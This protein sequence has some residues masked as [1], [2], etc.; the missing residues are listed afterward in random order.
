MCKDFLRMGYSNFLVDPGVRLGYSPGVARQ[1][2]NASKVRR[3]AGGSET[4]RPARVLCMVC[5]TEARRAA[6]A[7]GQG[8]A[9][10]L[11]SSFA[12]QGLCRVPVPL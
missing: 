7:A 9:R 12:M 10:R 5:R 1:V 2:Y 3:R 4:A 11:Q 8:Q 6:C